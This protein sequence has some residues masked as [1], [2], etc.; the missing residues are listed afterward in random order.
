[1]ETVVRWGMAIAF[2]GVVIGL[3]AQ[4]HSFTRQQRQRY[5]APFI[6]SLV[7]IGFGTIIQQ[8]AL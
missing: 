3:C 2:L 6:V 7:L 5:K 4:F 8:V 1:M